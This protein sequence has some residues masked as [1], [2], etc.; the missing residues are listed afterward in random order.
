MPRTYE[1][2]PSAPD[3]DREQFE[4]LANTLQPGDE[5]I[6]HAGTYSQNGRRA[7]TVKG[8]PDRP[9]AIRAAEGESPLFTAGPQKQ[10]H[11]VH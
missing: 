2:Q 3:A 9:I 11:R 7:A 10:W 8:T 6:V 4:T 5:L 1:C